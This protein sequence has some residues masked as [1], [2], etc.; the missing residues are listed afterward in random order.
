MKK[1]YINLF[2]LGFATLISGGLM[3][4]TD[5]DLNPTQLTQDEKAA[6]VNSTQT[7]QSGNAKMACPQTDTLGTPLLSGNGHAGNMFDVIIGPADITVKTFWVSHDST[8]QVSIYYKNGT[9]VGNESNAAA[10]TFLASG[11]VPGNGD[12]LVGVIPVDIA[13]TLTAGQT[14]AFYV[15]DENQTNFNYTNG[16]AVGS[17]AA[18]NSDLAILEGNGGGFFDVTFTPRVFNGVIEYCVET[19]GIDGITAEDL[20]VYP[21]PASTEL[22][23]DLSSLPISNSSVAI[24]NVLGE[25]VVHNSNLSVTSNNIL[26]ISNLDAGV[27]LVTINADGKE[28]ST[29]I[30]VD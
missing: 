6:I 12:G 4:Q 17:T 3:A 25:L 9:F 26:D 15:T 10:W 24:Y 8:D 30:L 18:S 16:T 23:I 28:L 22:N 11:M 5:A 7:L 14:Y 29:K 2:A 27:Y 21:N 13:L 20:N 19:G 1:I